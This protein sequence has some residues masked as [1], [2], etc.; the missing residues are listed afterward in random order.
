[1]LLQ[2]RP[3][4][5]ECLLTGES[6]MPGWR[7]TLDLIAG[8]G[9]LIISLRVVITYKRVA[10]CTADYWRR[11]ATWLEKQPWIAL[12]LGFLMGGISSLVATSATLE[13]TGKFFILGW[14]DMLINLI[15]GVVSIF[16]FL[17]MVM[18][19]VQY[20]QFARYLADSC[21]YWATWREKQ[22]WLT[23]TLGLL[24]CVMS[25]LLAVSV[26][27]NMGKFFMVAWVDTLLNLFVVIFFLIISL[28]IFIKYKQVRKEASRD[29]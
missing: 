16:I 27:F 23:L 9:F 8:I 25:V 2:D 10:R 19:I 7:D 6:S 5:A 18:M 4:R 22:P 28:S 26:A 29:G 13:I 3:H 12:L 17:Y 20:K 14:R 15:A 24:A 11:S 1:M 21:R